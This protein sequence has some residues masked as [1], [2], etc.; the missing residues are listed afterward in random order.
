M[1]ASLRPALSFLFL[2]TLLAPMGSAA[3]GIVTDGPTRIAGDLSLDLGAGAP[4]EIALRALAELGPE[5]GIDGGDVAWAPGSTR[6]WRGR[7]LVRLQ[8]LHGGVPVVGGRAVVKL[9]RGGRVALVNAAAHEGL[10][11]STLPAVPPAD[12]IERA[13]ATLGAPADLQ[14]TAALAVQ[15]DA[16]G[17][18]LIYRVHLSRTTRPDAWMVTVDAKTGAVREVTDLRRQALGYAFVYSPA[19]G[20]EQEV[21][22]TDL[23]GDQDVMN[24]E[25]AIVRSMV[26][27]GNDV[28]DIQRAVADES[29]D[30][31]YLPEFNSAEDAFVEVQAYYHVTEIS[32]FFEEVLGHEFDGPA[33]VTTNYLYED[34]SAFDNAFYTQDISGNQLLA[35]GQG[36]FDYAYDAGVVAHEFGHSIIQSTT[37][38]LM[39]WI[40]YDEY[41]ANNAPNGI[42][43]GLADYW[44]GSY[45]D[46]SEISSHIPIGRDLDNDKTCP[47]DLTGESHDDGEIVGAAA[48]D[49]YQQVGKEAADT[50]VYGALLLVSQAPTFAELAE[51]MIE[52]AADLHE[53]GDITAEDL[54]AIEASLDDRGMLV[55]GRSLPIDPDEP[56]EVELGL[57]MGMTELD[58][59]WC[60]RVREMGF[61]F[62]PAFQYS[63]TTP[64]EDEG[65]LEELEIAIDMDRYD[66]GSFKEGELLYTFMIR[67]GEMV[68]VDFE[69]IETPNGYEMEVPIP[70]E[71]DRELDENPDEI[72]ITLEDEDV[73]LRNDTTYYLTLLHKNCAAVDM[74]LEVEFDLAVVA[75]DDDDDDDGDG[76]SCRLDGGPGP[77]ALAPVLGLVWLGLTLRRRRNR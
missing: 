25:Y 36:S 45:Q 55:C 41:G 12:A 18:S 58:E 74:T 49:I 21:S 22:L 62:M 29:G 27:E 3:R 70:G 34:G 20:D 71:S 52:T 68:T 44:A 61:S 40:I 2:A 53:D 9:E 72:V 67:E 73:E 35:F 10:G 59:E 38:M 4:A 15:P 8:Q 46:Q 66:G 60:D 26:I 13:R 54:A 19:H 42:H 39:D 77:A 33:L 48:W 65:L 1:P 75:A 63:L 28:S 6:E 50:I 31:L 11:V 14:A 43:E 32:H 51:A 37:D 30:F 69:T 23:T 47:D 24:G 64:P 16:G 17:G 5:L 56:F 7:T 76:C 57:F